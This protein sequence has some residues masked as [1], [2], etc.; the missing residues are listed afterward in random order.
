VPAERPSWVRALR[1][2]RSRL[3]RILAAERF[4]EIGFFERRRGHERSLNL[5]LRCLTPA[6][7]AEFKASNAFKVRGESGQRYRITYGTTAN[8]EVLSQSGAVLRQLCAGPLELPTPAVM[9]AQKLMLEN[10]E[11]EFLRIARVVG[12]DVN[13][14]LLGLRR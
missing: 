11:A 1:G 5:L 10:R 7:R 2:A 4:A 9:L 6:Q 13:L 8:V 3:Q 12:A 14:Q